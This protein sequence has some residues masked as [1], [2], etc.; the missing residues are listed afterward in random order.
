MNLMVP[1]RIW[2]LVLLGLSV[3]A[4]P[5]GSPAQSAGTAPIPTQ[6]PGRNALLMGTD[7]YP[8]QWPETRWETDLQMMEASHLNVV[9]IAE[10]AWSRMEPSGNRRPG[11]PQP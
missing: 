11:E 3:I 2:I 9:R 4:G 8:E 7:W 1:R 6:I 5:T 10:F